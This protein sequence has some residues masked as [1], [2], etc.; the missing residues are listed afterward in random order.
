MAGKTNQTGIGFDHQAYHV[1]GVFALGVLGKLA[2]LFSRPA[3]SSLASPA[4]KFADLADFPAEEVIPRLDQLNLDEATLSPLQKAWRRDGVVHLPGFIPDDV[5]EAYL[6]RREAHPS[7]AGWLIATPYMHIPQMRDLALYPPMMEIMKS[8][9]GEDMML[10][11]CLTGWISSQREWHQD[12]YLNPGFVNSWYAAVWIALGDIHPD[13]GPFEYVPGSHQWPLMRH[14]KVRS[15]LTEEE[16]TRREPGSGNNHW[17]KYAERFVTPAID[18][19][20]KARGGKIVP[21]LAKRGDVLIWHGR[22]IH[23]GSKPTVPGMERRSLIA[24]YSGV[25]H[26]PDM[27]GRATDENGQHYAVFDTPLPALT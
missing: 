15:H 10:H 5:T 16:L 1:Q 19:E 22:L 27:P 14:D 20:I 26:R 7:N 11:L 24:H 12:D 25:S 17:E 23:R 3:S 13:S 18:A 2:N 9:I 4:I 8:L 21:L 6:R